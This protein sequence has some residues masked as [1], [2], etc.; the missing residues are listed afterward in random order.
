MRRYSLNLRRTLLVLG[1]TLVASLGVATTVAQ[2]EVVNDNNQ[3]TAGVDLTPS[4]RGIALPTGVNADTTGNACT[5]PWLS[6]DLDG[7]SLPSDALCYRGG[8]VM[9]KNET[10]ALTWDQPRA[11]WSQTR[12]YVEQFLR[13]EAD[14]SGSLGSPFALTSQYND[15]QGP[16]LN[17]SVFG[18]GCI[19]YGATGGSACEFGS[20]TGAGHDYPSNGCTPNPDGTSFVDPSQTMSNA[21]CLTDA[22][23]QGE[24]S[25]MITQTGMIGRTQPGY[26]PL[27]DLLLPPGVVA[28]LDSAGT[29]CSANNFAT[30]P[31][32]T[33][34]T[35][36][37]GGSL[38]AGTYEVE[39]TYKTGSGESVPSAAQWITT[40]GGT[41][42]ITIGSPPGSNDVSGWYAYITQPNG[43]NFERIQSSSTG[44]DTD[45]TLTDMS[46]VT[47]G[48]VPTQT[49]FCSYHSKVDVGGTEVA[50]VVQPWTAGTSCDEPGL[51]DIPPTPTPQ[52]LSVA[53]GA[54]L[55]SPLSQSEIAAIINPGVTDG[56]IGQ[57]GSE[58]EDNQGCY[59]E[60][61]TLDSVTVGS[62]SQ[63]PYFLQREWNNGAALE[64]DPNTYGCAPN[65]ILSPNFVVPSSINENDEVQFDG[66]STASTLVVPNHGYVWDFGDGTT[67]TGPSVVHSY[68]NA[69]TYNVKLTVTDR[70]DNV[71]TITQSVQVLG[72]D[73]SVAPSA[74][75]PSSSSGSGSGSG[76][77]GAGSAGSAGLSVHLQL[78]PQSLK[79]VLR[80]G[81]AVRVSSNRAANGVATL[82]ITRA[83]ARRA[84][85]QTGKA[86]AVRIGLGTVSSI[87]N[88]TVTLRLH[89]SPAMAQKLAHLGHVALTLRLQLVASGSQR[90]SIDAAGR[91]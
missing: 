12:G 7:P 21:D 13:D 38:P 24:L 11:Y 87:T 6:G 73:G 69:G 51:P 20:P 89:L 86:G 37:S 47:G 79:S 77:S 16:A 23:L 65:V 19:D 40:T 71:A 62:S 45:Y 72:S 90:L 48:S 36:T 18:G 52:Q 88:G 75:A 57:G 30:P 61:L 59:P 68:A 27:V 53:V 2:A 25:T 35:S 39:L 31:P 44:I 85:I 15:S 33:L 55:V 66:S 83:A 60:P 74:P 81:I 78:L 91:Y 3:A 32:P 46:A 5:D 64:F 34:S 10:F 29:L 43:F 4:T 8:S 50:Y 42:T 63:N 22:Q 76:G 56:W 84:H 49:A 70:G 54:R 28:C 67:A 1:A 26:T 58:I 82:W 14:G 9:H 80:S 17:A 41:S